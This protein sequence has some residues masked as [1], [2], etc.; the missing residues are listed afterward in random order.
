[1]SSSSLDT[2][3]EV[4]NRCAYRVNRHRPESVKES[5]QRLADSTDP[6]EST[7]NYGTGALIEQFERD[8]A[9]MLG[10]EAAVFMPSGTQAQPIA[11]RIWADRAGRDYVALPPTSHV[12]LYEHNSYQVLYGLKGVTMG[13]PHTVPQ[14][15]DLRNAARDPLAA[16]LLELP[17]REIG[18]QLP[19][20]DDLV[21]QS[22]WARSRGIKLHMDGARLWQCPAAYDKSLDEIAGLFDSVYVSFYKDLGGIAGAVLAG[23]RD[24]IDSAR[25]WQRRAGGTLYALYP[26]VIAAR[27]GLDRHRP[28]MPERHEQARWLARELNRIP[29]LSTW[30]REPHTAMFRL[31]F[32]CQP[33]QWLDRA[34]DWM[35]THD[36]SIIP[37]PYQ[38]DEGVIF[39]EISLGDAF[40]MLS[41]EQ[42]SHW[43]E[44]FSEDLASSAS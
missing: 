35:R 23:D 13:A 32:E 10:K 36:V 1:M 20:W 29:G 43:I 40:G 18:G 28:A 19:K 11:L 14:L 44:R 26:Y 30:P 17:M 41:R 39:S 42:W 3:R 15:T 5:L 25:V 22:Q 8:V 12:T 34:A 2:Y 9:T 33:D 16:I 21:E 6:N 37:P 7:D 27:A 24:F 38:V 31:R 4:S